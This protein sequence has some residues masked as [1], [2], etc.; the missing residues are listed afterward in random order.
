M[1]HCGDMASQ[2]SD[3]PDLSKLKSEVA[4]LDRFTQQAGIIANVSIDA[5]LQVHARFRSEFLTLAGRGVHLQ[6]VLP[7]ALG[8][9]HHFDGIV[10]HLWQ[11]FVRL[12]EVFL[13]EMILVPPPMEKPCM[14]VVLA[15]ECQ[16]SACRI[17]TRMIYGREP[18]ENLSVFVSAQCERAQ[19]LGKELRIGRDSKPD[20]EIE[21]E[22]DLVLFDI[23]V[24]KQ[25]SSL[26]FGFSSMP[27][28]SVFVSKIAPGGWGEQNDIRIHDE[29]IH[30]DD[31]P[32]DK[33]HNAAELGALLKRRPVKLTFEREEF[34]Q[35]GHHKWM[36]SCLVWW[37]ECFASIRNMVAAREI[38][39]NLLL[40]FRTFLDG[41]IPEG[42]IVGLG[43]ARF[44]IG[45]P[46]KY[47][48]MKGCRALQAIVEQ[49]GVFLD[50]TDARVLAA[51]KRKDGKKQ[52]G[53]DTRAKKDDGPNVEAGQVFQKVFEQGRKHI[54]PTYPGVQLS[55]I[56]SSIRKD[57]QGGFLATV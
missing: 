45:A 29:L 38:H 50:G 54:W 55:S 56:A 18:D 14:A 49:G 19:A 15:C 51:V 36:D 8:K 42:A 32:V 3:I 28:D 26:G 48:D 30:V 5:R 22:L 27:P 39:A 21:D 35:V 1:I 4:L 40:P 43:S 16:A 31:E 2:P 17:M 23:E 13:T 41:G 24:L 20:E 53:F 44:K 25:V 7:M 34:V 33:L 46:G 47:T 37:Q 11:S 10:L 57:V 6:P 9:P 12:R 52:T